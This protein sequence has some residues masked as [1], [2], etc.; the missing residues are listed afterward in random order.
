MGGYDLSHNVSAECGTDLH[1]IGIFF[2]F[3]LCTVSSQSCTE[4]GGASWSQRPAQRGCSHQYR[5]G[6]HLFDAVL[7]NICVYIRPKFFQLR[8]SVYKYLIRPVMEQFFCLLIRIFVSDIYRVNRLADNGSQFFGFSQQFICHRMDTGS[9]LFYKDHN[10]FPLFFVHLRLFL[11]L[12]Q[13]DRLTGT[14]FHAQSAHPAGRIDLY[15]S[16]FYLHCPKRT[17]FYAISAK[18]TFFMM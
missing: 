13:S 8:M 7:Q 16:V 17:V 12:F 14:V 18:R 11:V 15:F 4:P 5:T 9:F 10:A 3:Q 2:H 6:T 1:Q